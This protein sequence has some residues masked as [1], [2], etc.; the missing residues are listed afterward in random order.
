MFKCTIIGYTTVDG[1]TNYVH[2]ESEKYVIMAEDQVEK[3]GLTRL[4]HH[5][6][7]PDFNPG[8]YLQHIPHYEPLRSG[9]QFDL[10]M[11]CTRLPLG[12]MTFPL[13]TE[14]SSRAVSKLV[15]KQGGPPQLT[16]QE[17]GT[18]MHTVQLGNPPKHEKERK[19][20]SKKI[21]LKPAA[22]EV[23]KK[24]KLKLGSRAG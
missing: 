12:K 9:K 2:V 3:H 5:V 15:T 17:L 14:E 16:E 1:K 4:L 22:G 13:L 6:L 7:G 23:K 18:L 19:Q 24:I 20:L 21:S 8:D 10:G 11:L